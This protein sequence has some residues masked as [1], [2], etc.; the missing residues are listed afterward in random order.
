MLHKTKI[1]QHQHQVRQV[2][3]YFYLFLFHCLF[4]WSMH[5]HTVENQISN[6]SIYQTGPILGRNS[7]QLL[8]SAHRNIMK[9]VPF[10][11]NTDF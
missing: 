9:N 10:L 6:R 3:M 1:L 5:I 2:K 8:D 4:C 7:V 11:K